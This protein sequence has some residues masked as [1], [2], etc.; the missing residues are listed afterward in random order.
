MPMFLFTEI[1][2]DLKKGGVFGSPAS[3]PRKSVIFRKNDKS[4]NK[5][6]MYRRTIWATNSFFVAQIVSYTMPTKYTALWPSGQGVR[7]EIY[8][9]Y[10]A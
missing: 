2:Q 1:S 9:V 7:L 3:S 10:P 5:R 8:W 6:A 4:R